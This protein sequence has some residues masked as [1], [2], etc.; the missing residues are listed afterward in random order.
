MTSSNLEFPLHTSLNG[1]SSIINGNV[2]EYA[3]EQYVRYPELLD[4]VTSKAVANAVENSKKEKVIE[5]FYR[6]FYAEYDKLEGKISSN[7]SAFV[8]TL[9]DK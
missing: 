2:N 8:T 6:S 4:G 3:I 1:V 9:F 7:V 5:R